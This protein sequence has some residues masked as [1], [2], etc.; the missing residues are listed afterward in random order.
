MI[1]ARFRNACRNRADTDFGNE[2][3]RDRAIRIDVL[4]IVDELREV[5]DGINIVMRRRRNQSDTRRRV[6][7]F[8]DH[9]IDLVTR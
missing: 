2:L 6:A 7:H 8:R 4:Q 1:R 3:D 5:F 9:G